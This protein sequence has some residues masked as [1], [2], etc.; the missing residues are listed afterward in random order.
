MNSLRAQ[1]VVDPGGKGYGLEKPVWQLAVTENGK[2]TLLNAGPKDE[3]GGIFYVKRSGNPTIFE[4][5]ASFF[6]DLN[7][8]DTHFTK[9]VP[10]TA[11]LQKDPSQ[12][13]ATGL[14]KGQG[15]GA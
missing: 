10:S 3:K 11:K 14:P 9:D 7:V 12:N 13:I 6:D 4:L 15:Q 8:D 5:Q 2:E 1:K